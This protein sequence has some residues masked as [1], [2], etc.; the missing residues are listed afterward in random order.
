MK[1]LQEFQ[2][3]PSD[4]QD[5]FYNELPLDENDIFQKR[6]S[7]VVLTPLKERAK[8]EILKEE[9]EKINNELLRSRR[10]ASPNG[11]AR[12]HG[13]TQSQ[14]LSNDAEKEGKAE[15]EATNESSRA[16]VSESMDNIELF[17]K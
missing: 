7:D 3:I 17:Y 15:A 11:K 5:P 8:R 1:I 9:R 12:F 4:T 13:Q 6:V 16:L 10:Q 2:E 14:Y